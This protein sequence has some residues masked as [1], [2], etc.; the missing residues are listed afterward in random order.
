M[1]YKVSDF[2]KYTNYPVGLCSG[3]KNASEK[4]DLL[5]YIISQ[6]INENDLNFIIETLYSHESMVSDGLLEEVGSKRY[7]ITQKSL[8]MIYEHQKEILK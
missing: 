1:K 7:K 3:L 2:K 5:A 6:L 8:N 4:E